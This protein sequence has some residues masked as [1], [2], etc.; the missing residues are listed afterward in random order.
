MKSLK[1]I[2]SGQEIFCH[3][4]GTRYLLKNN[5]SPPANLSAQFLLRFVT[6]AIIFLITLILLSTS[7]H[8]IQPAF[9]QGSVYNTYSSNTQLNSATVYTRNGVSIATASGKFVLRVPPNI[10]T[11][12]ATAP[13]SCANLMSGIAAAPGKIPCIKIGVSPASTPIGYVAGR[14]INAGS[15]DGIPGALIMTDTGGAAIASGRDGSYRLASPSGAATISI[16]ADGFS[17]K[18][19]REYTIYPYIATN[20]N[21][22]LDAAP[23]RTFPVKGVITDACT[24]I[25]INDAVIISNTGKIAIS[26]DGFFSIDTPL[27]L[28]TLVVSTLLSEDIY[29][30]HVDSY[31]Y[32]F[33]SR[34]FFLT[35]L[36][37][38][39]QNFN[40]TPSKSITG[41]VSGIITNSLSGETITGVKVESDIN[42]VSYSQK[43][44]TYILYTSTCAASLSFSRSGFEP[45]ATAISFL[46]DNTIDCDISMT[47]LGTIAG[48][49]RDSYTN[50]GIKAARIALAEDR[51]VS[52]KSSD[53]GSYV[54][55]SIN[56]GTYTL[57]V[58]HP[59]YLPETRAAIQ[60]SAGNTAAEQFMLEASARA[61]MHGSVTTFFARRPIPS[62][63]ITTGYGATVTTDADGF[64]AIELPACTT[65]I[66]I[67]A[68]GFLPVTKINVSPAEGETSELNVRLFPWPFRFPADRE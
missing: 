7:V 10:Y 9:I 50:T 24:G 67:R 62:A 14:I 29:D 55:S 6:A 66:T 38:T 60:V 35:P 61:T 19:V 48:F 42:A 31:D 45:T 18:E 56:T 34:T 2:T 12:L 52:C 59:C 40:L 53:D 1:N 25:R 68:P 64:Y 3:S 58:S 21:I 41:L 57:E 37:N 8:A 28:S 11:L 4:A 22:S 63:S 26:S 20:L 30:C 47:P 51:T 44:G 15:G 5:F 27:G 39:I 43:D 17:S 36:S 49:V 33:N 54:L 32:Q 13:A 23:S 65:R 46:P 16:T